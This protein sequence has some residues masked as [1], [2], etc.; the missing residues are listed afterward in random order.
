MEEIRPKDWDSYIGQTALKER[1]QIHI[2]AAL[3]RGE[4]LD[5]ILLVGPPGCGKTTLAHLIAIEA[6]TFYLSYVMPLK[7]R[8][9]QKL[10]RNGSYPEGLVVLFDEIHRLPVAQQES[11]LSFVEDGYMQLDN[12]S[13]I[14][15]DRLTIV[16]ATTEPR[17]VIKPLWDRFQIKPIFEDYTDDEMGTIVQGMAGRLGFEIPIETAIILGRAT[18]GVPRVA[19]TFVGMARDLRTV[20]PI[21]IFA[22]CGVTEDGLDRNHLKYLHFLTQSGGLAGLDLISTHLGLPKEVVVD[23]EKLLVKRDY[24]EYTSSGRNA[25]QKA[26]KLTRK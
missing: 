7:P 11:L 23:L 16:G 26:Y 15:N 2:K 3:S 14:E 6:D 12:G 20:D 18:G 22:K 8:L 19:K 21:V 10:I 17:K 24:I 1:L 9:M 13:Q 5:H 4:Q 25:N